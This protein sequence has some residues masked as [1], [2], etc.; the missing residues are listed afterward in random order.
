MLLGN[1]LGTGS[2]LENVQFLVQDYS[3]DFQPGI[4]AEKLDKFLGKTKFSE[5]YTERFR[6][7]RLANAG[8]YLAG[9]QNLGTYLTVLPFND[10][11]LVKTVCRYH[12]ST[13]ELR[14]LTLS[15]LK[16]F[17]ELRDIPVDTTHLK[18]DA[19][20]E[21]HRFFRVLRMVMNVGFHK[22]I[23]LLQKGGP[24]KFRAF[25]YFDPL[26]SDF[27]ELVN[28]R[29]L[30]CSWY[31]QDLM[32]KYIRE[33][34]EIKGFNFYLHHGAETNILVLLRLAYTEYLLHGG[35]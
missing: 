2:K 31:N 22:K 20:Y 11:D 8:Y 7:Y 18:V 30:N 9:S 26:N 14:K 13:R 33:I 19:P 23:P 5:C 3:G 15:M 28:T 17:S 27:R 25:P 6:T 24:P 32:K 16:S 1:I 34:S 35:R 4:I 10:T 21:L 12:P 29:L